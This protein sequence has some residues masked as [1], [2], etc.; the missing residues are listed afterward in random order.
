MLQPGGDLDLAA[1]ALGTERGG[2]LR[3]EHLDRDLAIVPEV[4]G[5]VDG[6]HPAGADLPDQRVAVRERG[7]QAFRK[8]RHR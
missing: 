2:E 4:V 1:E 3:A 5:E 7:G 8:C 6:G